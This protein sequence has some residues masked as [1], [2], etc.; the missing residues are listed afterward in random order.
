MHGLLSLLEHHTYSLLFGWVLLEQGG[1][2]VPTIPLMLALGTMSAAHR[3]HVSLA[4]PLAVLACLIADSAW[5]FLGKFYG[6]RILDLLCR[7][8]F[9]ASTCV[10]R[11]EGHLQR[12]GAITLLFAKFVPGLS[13]MAPPIAGQAGI[14]YPVFLIYDAAGSLIWASAWLFA[15]RF[16]GDLAKRSNNFFGMLEHFGVLLVALMVVGVLVYRYVKRRQFLVEL[17]GLRLEPSQLLAMIADA[18]RAGLDRPFIVD[19]R[20][21]LDVLTDPLV[22]PGALR[23]GPDELKQRKDIIPSD[24]DVVLYC[25]CPSEE[26]SAKVALELRR[27]GVKRVRP[28][29][30]GLQGWKDAGYPLDAVLAI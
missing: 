3:T 30:G 19:L 18:E 25:T 16:F 27:M 8:S 6:S 15:G 28:L 13:T 7:F 10:S 4:L 12:R 29:R 24:R 2:P 1:V 23:I 22:L 17:R 5:F 20:H 14:S 9:E 11:T 26:T 21:P